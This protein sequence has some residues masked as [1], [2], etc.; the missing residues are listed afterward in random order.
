MHWI[1]HYPRN[2]SISFKATYPLNSDLSSEQRYWQGGGV[3]KMESP[4]LF[5]FPP[6]H[7]I[8]PG[9]R[10]ETTSALRLFPVAHVVRLIGTNVFML[11]QKMRYLLLLAN[12]DVR[13]S[14]MKIPRCRMA[15]Y[16]KKMYFNACRSCSMI[17]LPQP[18]RSC[19]FV[20]SLL[21]INRNL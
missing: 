17:I 13:S 2:N 18:I 4:I 16:V 7:F 14:N 6:Q 3:I 21:Y 11:R 10:F 19:R 15:D 8:S 12:V 20:I 5:S 1:N 9:R